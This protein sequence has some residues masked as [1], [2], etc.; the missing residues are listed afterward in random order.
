MEIC[1]NCRIGKM[2]T[3]ENALLPPL[4]IVTESTHDNNVKYTIDN[5]VKKLHINS[6]KTTN[7]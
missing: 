7:I 5:I 3:E 4:K 2:K 6:F 1:C